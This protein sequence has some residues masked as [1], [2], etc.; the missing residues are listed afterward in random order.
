MHQVQWGTR[1]GNR[2]SAIRP[3]GLHKP[4]PSCWRRDQSVAQA[5]V[6]PVGRPRH[7]NGAVC[8]TCLGHQVP[9][10]RFWARVRLAMTNQA[11]PLL[12]LLLSLS[13]SAKTREL[14]NQFCRSESRTTAQSSVYCSPHLES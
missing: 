6:G 13:R 8:S 3:G 2:L 9:Q 4:S 7:C 14:L 12:L 5:E 10:P 1:K 11:A